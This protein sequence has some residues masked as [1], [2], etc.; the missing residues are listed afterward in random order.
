MDRIRIHPLQ[1]PRCRAHAIAMQF[2]AATLKAAPQLEQGLAKGTGEDMRAP[3]LQQIRISIELCWGWG[4]K[5]FHDYPRRC[6]TARASG[7]DMPLTRSTVDSCL[8]IVEA[9]SE[10]LYDEDRDELRRKNV[11][12][13][14]RDHSCWKI[15]DCLKSSKEKRLKQAPIPL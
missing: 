14:T 13:N 5:S 6:E 4:G 8:K 10:V 1:V 11:I 15:P 12:E 7:A 2:A 9:T 3:T